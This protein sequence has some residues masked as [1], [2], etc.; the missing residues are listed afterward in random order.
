MK[1][2][3]INN[4]NVIKT[5]IT[6]LLNGEIICY[7]TDTIYGI[8]TD[9]KNESGIKKINA[10]KKR[11]GPM[12]IIINGFDHIIQNISLDDSLKEKTNEILS[13]GD[14]CIMHYKTQF[15]SELITENK[16][17]GFRVPQHAFLHAL[18]SEYQRPITSTSVNKTNQ[19]P[20]NNPNS[21]EEEFGKEIDLLIDAGEIK[22][23]KASKI[24]IFDNK[25]ITQIR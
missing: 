25:T 16:K 24:Y 21:I 19:P 20:L 5:T 18:L 2:I 8:G 12:T 22:N 11:S 7:P 10:I 23:K 9:A 4:K 3:S 6:S 13:K 1:R 15:V 17:I 14:T